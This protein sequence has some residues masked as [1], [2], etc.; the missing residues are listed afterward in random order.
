MHSSSRTWV[1][2]HAVKQKTLTRLNGHREKF[3]R[4]SVAWELNFDIEKHRLEVN[5]AM[6]KEFHN[7]DARIDK[8]I[9]QRKQYLKLEPYYRLPVTIKPA[10]GDKD[11]GDNRSTVL[12][13]KTVFSHEYLVHRTNEDYLGREAIGWTSIEKEIA[14]WPPR[15]ESKYEGDERISTDRLHGRCLGCPRV[16]GNETVNWMQR[17]IIPSYSLDDFYYPVPDE[18]DLF[19]RNHYIPA[20]EFDDE[21][22]KE[23]LGTELMEMLGE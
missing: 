16:G 1:A 21:S 11:F 4:N 20:L 6:Q 9:E 19:I 10:F 15:T 13:R 22:G 5:K 2:P 12:A 18:M 14:D 8:E 23:A 3:C 7:R 17:S